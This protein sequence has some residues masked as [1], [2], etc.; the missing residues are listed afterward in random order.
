VKV[1]G[2]ERI[3]TEVLQGSRGENVPAGFDAASGA[4]VPADLFVVA[5]SSDLAEI[6][7]CAVESISLASPLSEIESVLDTISRSHAE[8]FSSIP[9]MVDVIGKAGLLS[10][11]QP[12]LDVIGKAG[13]LS[14]IQPTLDSI[15]IGGTTGLFSSIPPMVDVIGTAG[16][17][18]SIQPTLDSIRIGG[19]TGLLSSIPPMVDVIGKAGLLSSIPPMVDVIGMAGLLSSIQPTFLDSLSP[20]LDAWL[21]AAH[22]EFPTGGRLQLKRGDREVAVMLTVIAFL[23]VYFTLAV[24]IKHNPQVAGLAAADGPTPFEAAM[25]IG[26]LVYWA[27][28]RPGRHRL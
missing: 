7:V 1:T 28:M 14:S 9:P 10:S 17:L 21:R 15:R 27:W 3:T 5:G 18:S 6:Q 13:L 23:V 25:G 24:A 16:L 20:Y 2:G 22:P 12:T 26:A 8:L 11:I 19:T 4:D